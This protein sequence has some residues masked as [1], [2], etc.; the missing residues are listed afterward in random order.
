MD[1]NLFEL[2]KT[3]H[4]FNAK[5]F[6]YAYIAYLEDTNRSSEEFRKQLVDL[7]PVH[8]RG[9]TPTMMTDCF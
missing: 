2:Q 3:L 6:G 8:L 5:S 4:K 7:L 1:L 9:M